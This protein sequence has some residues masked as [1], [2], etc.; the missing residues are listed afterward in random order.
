MDFYSRQLRDIRK[1]ELRLNNSVDDH[2]E[3][4][5]KLEQQVAVLQQKDELPTVELEIRLEV[6]A[7]TRGNFNIT[8]L[9]AKAGWFPKYDVRVK[10]VQSPIELGY[11]AE[12]Y[13]QTG[14]DWDQVKLKFS[15]ANPNK[16]G[17]VPTLKPWHLNFYRNTVFNYSDK[18]YG[19]RAPIRE[20]SGI[21]SDSDGL[22]LPGVNVLVKGSTTGTVTDIN[23]RYSLAVPPGAE[24]VFSSV[25]YGVETRP[26]TDAA[27]NVQMHEDIAQLSDVVVSGYALQGR[28]AGVRIRGV[29]SVRASKAEIITTTTIENQTTVEIEVEKPYTIKSE[30]EQLQVDLKKIQLEA[31][32]QYYAVPKL[33]KDAFLVARI[34]NWDQHN[35][36]EGEANLYFEESYVGRSLLNAKSLEDTLDI[37][38]GRDRSLVIARE[39]VEKFTK[40][41]FIGGNKVETRAFIIQVRNQKSQPVN[42][43][44]MDQLPVPAISEITVAP[45]ELSAAKY[46][47]KTG[48]ITWELDL[49][50]KDQRDLLLSYQV[51]YPKR[52]RVLLE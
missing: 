33:D 42:I 39:A 17:Q 3:F 50:T 25:G 19:S 44:L 14:N 43:I 10:D 2:I 26:V 30:A 24:L 21:I 1:E 40:R 32:Y 27:M 46:D 52:E 35:L 31:I 49:A 18:L 23:G 45:E 47:E 41:R 9:V 11:K 29:S 28:T 12:V 16:S 6:N 7:A 5:H 22:A 34:I 4:Q 15:N 48:G 36:L 20:V 37:S 38:L 8:Y 51:K 13:Q